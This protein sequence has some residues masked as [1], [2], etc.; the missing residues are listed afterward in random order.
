MF[1]IFLH[2]LL[3]PILAM[4]IV[5]V[6]VVMLSKVNCLVSCVSSDVDSLVP[7]LHFYILSYF[8]PL[9]FAICFCHGKIL[10]RKKKHSSNDYFF[11]LVILGCFTSFCSQYSSGCSVT[12]PF[13]GSQPYV[14]FNL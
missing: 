1:T 4:Q 9:S 12:D 11:F 7:H 6:R 8:V 2:K 14:L 5:R 10:K 3:T 13:V